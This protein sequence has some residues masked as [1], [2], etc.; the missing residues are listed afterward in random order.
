[1]GPKKDGNK[2]KPKSKVSRN[3]SIELYCV[4]RLPWDGNS[5]MVQCD[6]CFGWFHPKCIG[7]TP[8]EAKSINPFICPSCH[9][10]PMLKLINYKMESYKKNIQFSYLENLN[11]KR[12]LQLYSFTNINKN[13]QKIKPQSIININILNE[14]KNNSN[15]DN[16]FI[17]KIILYATQKK[18]LSTKKNTKFKDLEIQKNIS[19]LKDQQSQIITP[20]TKKRRE[21]KNVKKR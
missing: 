18:K 4:C 2:R 17:N 7:V 16:Q 8:K 1:M 3:S 12:L 13:N 9:D 19:F 14:I 6:D 15:N 10:I 20:K 11:P 5:L 21:G